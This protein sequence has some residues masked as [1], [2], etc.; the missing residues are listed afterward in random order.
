MSFSEL[1]W[2]GMSGLWNVYA[3]NGKV[4]VP[5]L[6]Q[7]EAGFYMEK[8]PVEVAAETDEA[9][10][11][12]A[13]ARA[14]SRGNPS[15]PTPPRG[16][17][18]PPPVVLRPAGVRS[19]AALERIARTWSIAEDHGRFRLVPQKRTP[20]RGWSEDESGALLLPAGSAPFDAARRMAALVA[21]SARA[22][23][24]KGEL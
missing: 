5:T 23:A 10:I 6:A 24:R 8:E 4:V 3:C 1:S 18:L 12:A 21:E 7:T 16:A 19:W 17:K 14:M 2:R 22:H 13:I 20:P 11:A 15:I 9:A